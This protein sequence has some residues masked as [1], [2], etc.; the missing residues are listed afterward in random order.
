MLLLQLNTRQRARH[1]SPGKIIAYRLLPGQ[2]LCCDGTPEYGIL[3]IQTDNGSRVALIEGASPMLGRLSDFMKRIDRIRSDRL[4]STCGRCHASLCE[5]F[6]GSS[7]G[8]N[9]PCRKYKTL[10]AIKE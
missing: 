2:Q 7:C 9:F 5:D 6:H 4:V 8:A 1:A 3:H 10:I